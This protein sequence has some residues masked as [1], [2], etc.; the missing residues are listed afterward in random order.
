[1]ADDGGWV[2]ET[3]QDGL[4]RERF[5]DVLSEFGRRL[6]S[7]EPMRRETAISLVQQLD[8][9]ARRMAAEQATAHARAAEL[10]AALA[11]LNTRLAS[12]VDREAQLTRQVATLSAELSQVR[13]TKRPLMDGRAVR[14]IL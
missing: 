14:T 7:P 3:G 2:I 11:A 8:R 4:A 12:Y 9:L 10:D 5:L 1:M 6:T 13:A